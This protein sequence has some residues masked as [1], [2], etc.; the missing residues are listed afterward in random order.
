MSQRKEN[1]VRL[2][3]NYF[4]ISNNFQASTTTEH[5]WCFIMSYRRLWKVSCLSLSLVLCTT[6]NN[7]I[8]LSKSLACSSFRQTLST[9]ECFLFGTRK[10]IRSSMFKSGIQRMQLASRE[11][12]RKSRLTFHIV[13]STYSKLN[14]L[15]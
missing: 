12:R 8:C 15:Q 4:L 7:N 3:P 6:S 13:N 10:T 14:R 9:T 2:A 1:Y 11:G 5:R